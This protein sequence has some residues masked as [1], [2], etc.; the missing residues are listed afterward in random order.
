MPPKKQFSNKKKPTVKLNSSEALT[1][2]ELKLKLRGLKK[3][4]V[5][6]DKEISHLKSLG[7]TENLEPEM[8][9]LHEYNDVKDATQLV[10]GY[11][12]DVE[13][14]TVTDLHKRFN[15]PLE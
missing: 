13:N 12:A 6:L 4:S 9:A 10:L 5:T 3:Q 1:I 11:L 15:L 2:S 14:C 8:Q 7:I